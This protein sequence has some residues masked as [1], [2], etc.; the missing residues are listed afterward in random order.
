MLQRSTTG[1]S[2]RPVTIKQLLDAE[3]PHPD[4]DF[5]IDGSEVGHITFVGVV[6]NVVV[7]STN[8]TYRVEDGTGAIDVKQWLDADSD[9]SGKSTLAYVYLFLFFFFLKKKEKYKI[10]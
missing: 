1:N 4:A 5:K 7:Q 8:I 6:R 9:T 2:L 3:Q 10:K